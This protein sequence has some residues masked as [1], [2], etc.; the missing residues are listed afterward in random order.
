MEALS[1]LEYIREGAE[2]ETVAPT[3]HWLQRWG[4]G[5][6]LVVLNSKTDEEDALEPDFMPPPRFRKLWELALQGECDEWELDGPRYM[7]V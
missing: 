3:K 4:L 1:V 7:L 2:D 6:L 5:E